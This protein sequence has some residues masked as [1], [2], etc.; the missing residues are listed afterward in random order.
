MPVASSLSISEPAFKGFCSPPAL[1]ELIRDLF[2][3][4]R[5][6]TLTL[7]RGGVKKRIYMDRGMIVSVSSSL[8]DERLAAFLS[9][10]SCRNQE[11][12]NL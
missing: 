11:E 3:N 8:D 10:L 4:E 9:K 7:S 6:G 1:A 5:T 2:L 12:I